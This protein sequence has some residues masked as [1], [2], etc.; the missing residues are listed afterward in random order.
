LPGLGPDLAGGGAPP[1]AP[2]PTL[3]DEQKAFKEALPGWMGIAFHPLPP[4]RRELLRLDEGAAVV[5]SV[6]PGSPAEAAGLVPGDIVVGPPGQPFREEREIRLWTMLLPV[7][8]PQPLT[9]D[10]DGKRLRLTLVPGVR[11]LKLPYVGPPAPAAPAPPVVGSTYRGVH[12]PS[13]PFLLFFWA[14][15][16][17]PCKDSLPEVLAF[18]RQ[19]H[20]PVVAVT[21]EGRHDLDAFFT[22]F[23]SPFP[24]TVLSDENRVSFSAYAVSGTPTF[25]LV[26]D[27]HRV[28]SYAVGY[29]RSR[30]LALPGWRWD[31]R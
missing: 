19:R 31:G 13:G 28:Q 27:A 3:D 15:W 16:C 22:R 5:G 18:S 12:Q 6:M 2:F 30:G 24:A 7:G 25:V 11:P 1:S 26:D 17:G 23:R 14:T 10:R 9:V 4:R 29:Q 21:D 8:R 20:I